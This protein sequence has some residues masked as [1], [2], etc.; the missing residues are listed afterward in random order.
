MLL[1]FKP[2]TTCGGVAC[3]KLFLPQHSACPVTLNIIAS[4]SHTQLLELAACRQP[5]DATCIS[6]IIV[7]TI[8]TASCDRLKKA[9]AQHRQVVPEM[10]T[11]QPWG[12]LVGASVAAGTFAPQH[13]TFTQFV[14]WCAFAVHQVLM[15]HRMG[16]A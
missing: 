4:L 16:S 6:S 11:A 5:M 14:L 2:P 8:T 13:F 10:R 9:D 12:T 3:P 1:S 15:G 7:L